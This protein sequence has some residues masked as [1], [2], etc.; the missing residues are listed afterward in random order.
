MQEAD[1]DHNKAE[2][3]IDGFTKGFDLSYRGPQKR[4]HYSANIPLKNIGTESDLWNKIMNKVE[5]GRYAGPYDAPHL[6][7]SCNPQ[8]AWYQRLATRPG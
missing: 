1:Y 4:K 5:L 8:W 6:I 7:I 3:L 2:F